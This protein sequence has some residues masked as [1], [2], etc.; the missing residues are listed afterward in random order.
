MIDMM[1]MGRGGDLRFVVMAESPT[2]AIR[3]VTNFLV[4]HTTFSPLHQ[5]CHFSSDFLIYT[6]R[7]SMSKNIGETGNGMRYN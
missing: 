1:Y 3:M 2:L 7:L 4:S 6:S 5:R